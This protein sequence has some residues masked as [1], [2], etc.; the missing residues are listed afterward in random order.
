MIAD[1]C[2]NLTCLL[3]SDDDVND[4]LGVRSA[5][6]V[7]PEKNECVIRGWLDQMKQLLQ[8]ISATMDVEPKMTDFKAIGYPPQGAGAYAM[9]MF[10]LLRLIIAPTNEAQAENRPTM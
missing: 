3:Q 8:F 10:R 9:P 6:D 7:V 4:A 2:D 1:E 5:I